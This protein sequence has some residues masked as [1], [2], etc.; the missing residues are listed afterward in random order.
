M[1]LDNLKITSYE[2]GVSEL[3]DN[4]SD[5]GISA[6]A[7]KA[8]FDART[9]KEIKEKHNALVEEVER[10]EQATDEAIKQ[11]KRDVLAELPVI[12]GTP[13]KDG[14]SPTV[15][16]VNIPGGHRV[17]ITDVNGKHSFDVLDGSV[18]I[19]NTTLT[20]AQLKKLIALA[21]SVNAAEE[22]A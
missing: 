13:G 16:V 17:T 8:V 11:A 10:H 14:Y 22:G 20:E 15:A 4:P 3:P 19:E 18:I 1:A 2:D 6:Q 7:L 9:D 5:A 12:E 21:D